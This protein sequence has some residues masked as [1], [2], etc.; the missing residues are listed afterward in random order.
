M[1]DPQP[2]EWVDLHRLALM[3]DGMRPDLSQRELRRYLS[4]FPEDGRLHALLALTFVKQNRPAEAFAAAG[5]AM[6]LEPLHPLSNQAWA[7]THAISLRGRKAAAAVREAMARVHPTADLFGFLSLAI[8]NGAAL[9]IPSRKRG[10]AALEAAEAGLRLDPENASC[11]V[12]RPQAL[13]RL[14]RIPEAREA[15]MEALRMYPESAVAHAVRGWVEVAAWKRRQAYPHFVEALRLDPNDAF[16]HKQLENERLI[17]SI[18]RQLAP[19]NWPL[20]IA[21]TLAL[22]AVVP[23]GLLAGHPVVTACAAGYLCM[24]HP[25]VLNRRCPPEIRQL[26]SAPGALRRRDVWTARGM[27]VWCAFS[28]VFMWASAVE[29]P[30]GALIPAA[31]ARHSS[32]APSDPP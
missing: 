1:A 31:D 15:A 28:A 2:P 24:L 14:R 6:R 10:R 5:E 8:L 13:A 7:A 17:A 23:L 11:L 12:L 18:L 30:W 32:T 26:F 4:R 16:T 25:D 27:I 19:A 22:V 29:W 20:R 9:R 3:V 21:C